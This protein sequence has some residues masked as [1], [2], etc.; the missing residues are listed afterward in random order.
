MS[1]FGIIFH[2]NNME[3]KLAIFS[4]LRNSKFQA[5]DIFLLFRG[6]SEE[7][8][9]SW[10]SR[11]DCLLAPL[12]HSSLY[13]HPYNPVDPPILTLGS[14]MGLAWTMA[15]QRQGLGKH[16]CNWLCPYTFTCA[17]TRR[18]CLK[19]IAGKSCAI[20]GLPQLLA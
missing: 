20:L 6:W 17:I 3:V 9:L 10:S 14:P 15:C 18:T 16:V 13:P 1:Y 7:L 8:I 4:H 12:P 11:V 2:A 19:S 5:I